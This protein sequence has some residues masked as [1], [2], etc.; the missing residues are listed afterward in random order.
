MASVRAA[1]SRVSSQSVCKAFPAARVS[2]MISERT[3][4][5][6]KAF[7]SVKAGTPGG[8]SIGQL[9]PGVRVL[10]KAVWRLRNGFAAIESPG[11]NSNPL[12]PLRK[13]EIQHA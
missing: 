9:Q 10:P 6:A 3:A 4:E 7:A 11:A 2:A 12:S 8:A 1:R 5:D 13:R